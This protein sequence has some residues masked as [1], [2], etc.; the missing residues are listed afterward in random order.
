MQGI[1]RIYNKAA[2]KSYIGSSIDVGRR[3]G[4][5]KGALGRGS[6][7]NY[8]L[9]D[10]WNTSGASAFVFELVEEIEDVNLLLTRE[11][12][13]LDEGF[14]DECLY[15]LA[16]S[17]TGGN[18]PCSD[19]TRQ[20]MQGARP[21]F[22]PWNKGRMMGPDWSSWC[23]GVPLTE[24]HR[25]KLSIANIK[26][27]ETHD[28]HMTGKH[29]T[30]ETKALLSIKTTQYYKT[31]VHPRKN[32]INTEEHNRRASRSLLEHYKT[33]DVWNKGLSGYASE[34]GRQAMA[35]ARAK[36]YP[37]FYNSITG[38][39]IPPGINLKDLCEQKGLPYY[40]MWQ[41]KK[42]VVKQTRC[43]WMLT[44]LEVKQTQKQTINT[45]KTM[46][47]LVEDLKDE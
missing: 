6:H 10:A 35:R 3:L 29:H 23:R 41:I 25:E 27:L 37:A 20:K 26:W 32:A 30:D 13:Y 31:H 39:Y 4:E 22:I 24:K 18:G 21:D 7:I 47:E 17:T 5:H 46:Q 9:Q 45:P 14:I 38:D 40:S 11:Q 36:P 15:N 43:G 12:V 28:G 44:K 34:E 33:H 19:E 1:Y 16:R 8:L 2:R 42:G